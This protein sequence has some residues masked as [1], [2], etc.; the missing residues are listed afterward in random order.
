MKRIIVIAFLL[1]FGACT[2]KQELQDTPLAKERAEQAV[3][4]TG[5]V[6]RRAPASYVV[7]DA[8]ALVHADP[9]YNAIAEHAVT[10]TADQAVTTFSIDVDRAS[11]ANIRRFLAA[12]TLPPPAAV[13]IEE[14]L[15]Y[16]TWRYP[17]PAGDAPFAITTEVAGTPWNTSSRL[18][19]IGIQGR[20]LDEWKAA[21]NNLVFLIDTSGSMQPPNRLPL[22]KSAFRVLVDR[23]R[24]EDRVSIVTYAG[25]A[26][27]VLPPTSGADK[28]RI[29]EALDR[30][31]A[32]GSTAG[33][34]G[35]E[36]AYEVAQ[37]ELIRDGNNRVILATDGDFNVGVST[38]AELEELIE[39]KR[40]SGIFLSVIGVGDDNYQDAKMEL[41]ADKGNGN[42][43]Y[44]DSQR[45]AEKVFKRELTGTLVAIAKDVKVQLEF[46]RSKVESYRQIGYENRALANEDFED[47]SK[48]AGELGAGHSVTAL[49][50]IVMKPQTRGHVATVKLRYKEPAG[51]VSRLI[52]ATAVDEGRETFNASPDMHF[53]AAIAELGMLLR[54]SPHK[55]T[56][57]YADVLQ[58]ARMARGEDLDGLR[59]EFIRLAESARVLGE[60]R[61]ALNE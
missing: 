7:S 25:S 23:L 28:E 21:P 20:N 39:R 43:A 2:S 55:G 44:L 12:G 29:L 32:G 40:K 1:V 13:R 4:Q 41:L 35:I 42:Y 52:T 57:S 58:L 31:D 10:K 8:I 9:Q 27:L 6:Y 3:T 34:A 30:L 59:E 22:L 50:E 26:G 46:D 18:L 49:Y 37:Q 19:R 56:S 15:N 16:F 53:A 47:D 24:A 45:E 38:L 51:D 61:I 48:D 33:G 60:H 11:Y 54:N 36:L 5:A 14:M 17:Q